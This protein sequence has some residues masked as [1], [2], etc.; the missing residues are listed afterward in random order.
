MIESYK[1]QRYLDFWRGTE[2]DRP[3]LS[4]SLRSYFPLSGYPAAQKLGRPGQS[5]DPD[6]ISPEA[7]FA[8]YRQLV[9]ESLLLEDDGIRSISPLPALPWVEAIAGAKVVLAEDS[10]WAAEL[11][12][13]REALDHF[14]MEESNRWFLKLLEFTRYLQETFGERCLIGLPIL[15]GVSDL[16]VILRGHAELILDSCDQPEAIGRLGLAC[17]GLIHKITE[18]QHGITAGKNEGH[19]VELFHLWAPGK[20]MRFQEDNACLY[21]PDLFRKVVLPADDYLSRV[22]PFSMIHFHSNSLFMIDPF[23]DLPDLKVV[24]VSQ[25]VGGPSLEEQLPSLLKIRARGKGLLLRGFFMPEQLDFLRR[26]LAPAGLFIQT[27]LETPAD[28][29]QYDRFF[30]PWR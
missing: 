28:R 22:Y 20:I 29:K 13:P 5:L 23:L 26:N 8:D 19:G 4:F 25:D 6:A 12:L 1:I 11:N 9:E 21:S 18:A 30:E 16:M 10:I 15:R 27:V 14:H 7:F 2:V 17:A 3:L 24:Q